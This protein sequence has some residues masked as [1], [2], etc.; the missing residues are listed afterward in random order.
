MDLDKKTALV[1]LEEMGKQASFSVTYGAHTGIGTLPIVYFGTEAQQKAKYLP[2]L[3]SGR[4]AGGLRPHRG[5]QRAATPWAPRP[6]P[7]WTATTGC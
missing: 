6:P 3:A 2:M 4:M 1:L 7:C 5:R